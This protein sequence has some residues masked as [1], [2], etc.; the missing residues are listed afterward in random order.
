MPGKVLVTGAAGFI[1]SHVVR[2]LLAAG[3]VVRA[4]ARKPEAA[5][6]LSN[7]PVGH[8]GLLEIV[9]MELLNP[10]SVAVAVA[11][12]EEVIH[13]AAA[14]FV[15]AK[16]AQRDVVDPSIEGTRNLIAAI[17]ADNGVKRI[18]H[19]SSVAAI[20]A[21]Q[22]RSGHTYSAAD[23]CDDAT[24]KSNAYGLA[25]AGAERLIRG[26]WESQ[27]EG[28]R[29]RLVTIHPSIVI[30]PILAK[31]HLSGSMGFVDHLVKGKL[32]FVLKSHIEMV[33]VRDVATAH[34]A[35]LRKGRDGGRYIVHAG[36]LWHREMAK[37]LKDEFPQ[38]KWARR[39]LPKWATYVVAI[40]HS[41]I[42]IG[43]V[44]KN[45]G[46]WCDFDTGDTVE[47]LDIAW[48]PLSASIIDGAASIIE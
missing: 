29:P 28:E 26:W 18:V 6:F 11:G 4:T 39:Q 20:R 33:D 38:R 14:L 44:R 16:D 43:W 47:D 25:K 2:E 35:A 19:T 27:D 22:F 9:A 48:R 32:P 13:C 36:G 10:E 7:L 24:L 41:K 45:I 1:G 17:E 21:T 31:R 5:T 34:V 8:G 12:C 15:G 46:L 30:G 3:R 40:F 42:T 37:I 23:W